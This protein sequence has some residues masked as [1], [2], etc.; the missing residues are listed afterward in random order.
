MAVIP[1]KGILY[2]PQKVDATLIMAPPYDVISHGLKDDLYK[3]SPHNIIRIDF[4][5]DRDGDNEHE[6]RYTRA[7]D[8]LNEW[9]KQGVLT[10]DDDTYFY[11]YEISYTL[12]GVKKRTRGFLGAVKIEEL[13]KGKV[14]PHEMTYS[15]PKSDRL[16]ILRFCN[17]NTSPI[18]SL[19]SSE[20]KVTSSKTWQK[21]GSL[22]LTVITGMKQ[23]RRL[24][25]RWRKRTFARPGMNHSTMCSCFS[26]IWRKTD[27][28]CCRLIASLR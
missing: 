17:A 18:F 12:D 6:N 5:K 11:C 14:H 10:R 16:N 3:R 24:R 22:L 20:E 13:G 2:N 27:C 4:G 25:R 8:Y 15:K 26:P 1:F 9:L 19:Y 28:P 21:N 7:A 23:H